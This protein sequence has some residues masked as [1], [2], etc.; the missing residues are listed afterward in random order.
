LRDGDEHRFNKK[1]VLK[2]VDNVIK[3]IGPAIKGMDALNQADIDK[4]MID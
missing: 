2:A 3:K 4:K 1:G